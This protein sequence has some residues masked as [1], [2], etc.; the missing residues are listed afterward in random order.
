MPS[1]FPGMD[2]YLESPTIWEDFHANLAGEIQTQ[3]APQI[4]PKYIAALMPRVAYEEVIIGQTP[5][6]IKPD[7]AIFKSGERSLKEGGAAIAPAPIIGQITQEEPVK[8]FTVEIRE[9]ATDRLVTAIE[10]LSPVNKRKGHEAYH[11]YQRKRRDLMRSDVHL[12][13]IDLLRQ[14]ERFPLLSPLPDEPYFIFLHRG[15]NQV[16]IWPLSLDK[17]I[18]V[19]P[20]PLLP[21]DP[22]VPLDLGQAIRQ[23]YDRAYYNLR[24]DYKQPPPPPDLPADVGQ[25]LADHLQTA[26]LR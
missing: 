5:S 21:P 12:L 26:G 10:I 22:D 8:L 9:V 4:S 7:V 19:V 2:P 1:P 11:N 6:A 18:P 16:E 25:W 13:E 3:L 17:A 14:G 24:I 20:V 23:I 15:G